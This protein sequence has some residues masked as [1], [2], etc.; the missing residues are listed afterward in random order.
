MLVNIWAP[1]LLWVKPNDKG[2]LHLSMPKTQPGRSLPRMRRSCQESPY[3]AGTVREARMLGIELC[4]NRQNSNAS[5]TYMYECIQCICICMYVYIYICLYVSL[6][7]FLHL[8]THS[9]KGISCTQS[10]RGLT[11]QRRFGL[12]TAEDIRGKWSKEL[13]RR[14]QT[15]ATS[16]QEHFQYY[17]EYYPEGPD[18]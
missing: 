2:S 13:A 18:T 15:A 6:R 16:G 17:F 11:I 1:R 3:Q 4:N 7:P 9:L 8:F 12:N 10:A 14:F 5:L